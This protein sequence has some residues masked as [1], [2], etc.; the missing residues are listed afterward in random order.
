MLLD[1]TRPQNYWSEIIA[2]EDAEPLRAPRYVHWSSVCDIA[3]SSNKTSPC[4][5]SKSPLP[6]MTPLQQT[7]LTSRLMIIGSSQSPLIN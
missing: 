7:Q 6:A 3:G 2:A 1:R 4:H 5:K